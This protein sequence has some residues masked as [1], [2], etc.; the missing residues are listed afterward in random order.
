[1]LSQNHLTFQNYRNNHP[2]AFS[3]AGLCFP[4]RCPLHLRPWEECPLQVLFLRQGKLSYKAY[5]SRFLLFICS[6]A[7]N[8]P[9][10]LAGQSRTFLFLVC[11]CEIYSNPLY[12][13][14]K[15]GIFYSRRTRSFDSFTAVSPSPT[16]SNDGIPLLMSVSTITTYPSIPIKPIVFIFESILPQPFKTLSNIAT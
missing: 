9:G 1:V 7:V 5:L 13:K 6:V 15:T 12:R 11:R 4:H 3:M 8:T 10:L 14:L 2:S 16:M